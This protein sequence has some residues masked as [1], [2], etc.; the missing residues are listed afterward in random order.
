M[1]TIPIAEGSRLTG[2][3][4]TPLLT[5][6][7]LEVGMFLAGNTMQNVWR[8]ATVNPAAN[9]VELIKQPEITMLPGHRHGFTLHQNTTCA[10]GRRRQPITGESGLLPL[11]E[12]TPRVY[13]IKARAACMVPDPFT[14]Y[15]TPQGT[16]VR[17]VTGGQWS[18]L[19]PLIPALHPV[20]SLPEAL[21][22]RI[23]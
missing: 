23:Q 11:R 19:L 18:L 2:G 14:V 15:L 6:D 13:L 20:W 3:I 8:V 4:Q 9:Q 5:A 21:R 16:V 1:Q 17:V 12:N 10:C 7:Q 22:A